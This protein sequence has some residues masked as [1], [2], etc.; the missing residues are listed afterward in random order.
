MSGPQSGNPAASRSGFAALVGW[1]NVGKSTLLNRLVG[2][3]LAAVADVAQ[4]TRQRIQGA[5]TIAGRGQIVFV[6]T[7]GIHQPRHRLNRAMV[8]TVHRAVEE[9]DLVLLVLDAQCGIGPGDRRAAELVRRR[10][11]A[12]I[13]VLNKVDRLRQKSRL[14][15]MIEQLVD[16]WGFAEVVPVSALTGDGCERLLEVVLAQLP[17]GPPLFPDDY[18]TDQAER[19]IAAEWIREKLLDEIRQELPHA[20]AVVIDRWTERSDGLL[21]LEASVLVERESQKK[22]VIGRE[23]QLLKRVGSAARIELE[24]FFARRVHLRL[25]VSVCDGWRDDDAVLHRLGL[26]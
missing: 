15:P 7:P 25:W 3:R 13:A 2:V 16:E 24:R 5:T 19:V 26:D 22:I 14:L 20:T 10:A 17:V 9:V 21:E 18:L 12:R 11:R 8:E 23:G 4:T 1:T 6:D